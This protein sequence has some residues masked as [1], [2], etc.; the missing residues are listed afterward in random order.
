MSN[1]GVKEEMECDF[2]YCA[3][4]FDTAEGHEVAVVKDGRVMAFCAAH[5]DLLR[6]SG[7]ALRTL[8]SIHREIKEAREAPI[9]ERAKLEREE[10]EQAFIAYL[11]KE[12]K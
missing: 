5:C 1:F 3:G 10:R 6:R 7:V 11:K 4:D 12:G 8:E 9:R 2:V